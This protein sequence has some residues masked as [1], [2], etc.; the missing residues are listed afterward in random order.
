MEKKYVV[1]T[2][3][4]DS[5]GNVVFAGDKKLERGIYIVVLPSRGMTYFELL[6]GDNRKFSLE[7][8][9]TNFL[10]TMKVKGDKENQAFMDYQRKMVDIQNRRTDLMDIYEAAKDNPDEQKK[11]SE[12]FTKLNDER[13]SFMNDLI[14]K[15]PNTLLSKILLSMIDPE[16][17]ESP[18]DK[19]GN[20]IDLFCI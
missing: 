6:I 15:N 20:E 2:A 12:E 10:Q 14:K 1:D 8:D 5:K 17:P 4:V 9:T 19:D 3:K 13:I 18:K 16:I 7:T 11:I